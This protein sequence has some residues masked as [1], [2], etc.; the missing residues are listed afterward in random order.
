VIVRAIVHSSDL[1]CRKI[2]TYFKINDRVLKVACRNT[3]RRIRGCH[4][5]KRQRKLL[6]LQTKIILH[7]QFCLVFFLMQFN[8]A[9]VNEQKVVLSDNI[10][11]IVT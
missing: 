7:R 1:Q 5:K 11:F 9:D 3:L 6:G 4:L 2:Y 8:Y 10:L